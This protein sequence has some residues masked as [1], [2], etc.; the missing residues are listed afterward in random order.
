M[1]KTKILFRNFIEKGY[2]SPFV[3][4]K[5]WMAIHYYA[6]LTCNNMFHD[7][8][9]QASFYRSKEQKERRTSSSVL[10]G[11]QSM[12]LT[13]MTSCNKLFSNL[14]IFIC[15]YLFLINFLIEEKTS[16]LIS[17]CRKRSGIS[18]LH[19]R[20][21]NINIAYTGRVIFKKLLFCVNI[22]HKKSQN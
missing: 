13:R 15:S 7:Y 3:Y 5:K 22:Y 17:K 10:N 4:L 6:I 19:I 12:D 14:Y 20:S 1:S 2:I 16:K 8:F 21:I 18:T 9:R 11:L